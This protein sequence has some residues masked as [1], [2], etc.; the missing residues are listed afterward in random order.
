MYKMAFQALRVNF[1]L[2]LFVAAVSSVLEIMQSNG[3]AKG[4]FVGGSVVAWI[5]TMEMLLLTMLL[6]EVPAYFKFKRDPGEARQTGKPGFFVAGG[7]IQ[8]LTFVLGIIAT[9][10]LM[11]VYGASTVKTLWVALLIGAVAAGVA[12][13]IFGSA[14]PAAVTGTRPGLGEALMRAPRFALPL[15]WRLV[16][17][18]GVVAVAM[19][20]AAASVDYL[21]LKVLG[22][23]DAPVSQDNLAGVL[24]MYLTNLIGWLPTVFIAAALAKVW[25]LMEA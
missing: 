18:P 10:G 21:W 8:F 19:M 17:G 20:L 1:V 25:T 15:A 23:P 4:A 3:I 14:L 22:M 24:P 13:S 12:L 16:V 11:K 5:M 2:V 6:G 9:I 7:V